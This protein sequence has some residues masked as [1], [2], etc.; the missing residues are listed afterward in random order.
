MATYVTKKCPHCGYAYQIF[1]TGEQRKYGCPYNICTRCNHP[2][3]DKD[4]KE[5]ALYGYHNVYEVK[6]SILRG[7]AFLLY[8]SLGLF[9]IGACIFMLKT[10][11]IIGLTFLGMAVFSFWAIIS[12]IKEKRYNLVHQSEIIS[13]QQRNY[14]A[15][16]VRLNDTNYLTALAEYDSRARK[17]LQERTNGQEEHYAQRPELNKS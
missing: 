7:I 10:D 13:E 14:D 4:T 2:Y 15:S 11:T 12:Y 3:W 16:L 1:Q 9:S 17:L 8:I 6:Q 5:P